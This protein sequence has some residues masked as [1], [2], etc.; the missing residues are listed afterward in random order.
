MWDVFANQNENFDSFA[1]HSLLSLDLGEIFPDILTILDYAFILHLI[2]K[3]TYTVCI[4]LA[5][6][7]FISLHCATAFPVP[8]DAMSTWLSAKNV[9]FELA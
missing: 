4:N 9:K 6:N 5:P 1:T 2:S 3:S 7:C 8:T